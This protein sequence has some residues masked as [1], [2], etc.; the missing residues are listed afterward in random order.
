ML[1]R[2]AEQHPLV[3][4]EDVLGAIAMVD[5]E[6]DDRDPAQPP[7][8]GPGDPDR[9]VVEEAEAHGPVG[10]GVVARRPYQ[11]KCV[12]QFTKMNL[13]DSRAQPSGG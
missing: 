3:A 8:E 4:R 11:S 7:S 5:V 13:R 6:V 12:I 1:K 9:D 2:R 10:G